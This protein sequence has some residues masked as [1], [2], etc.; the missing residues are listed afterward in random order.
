MRKTIVCNLFGGACVGKS[1][2]MAQVFADLKILGIECEMAPEYAKEKVW[3]ESFR[4]MDD[5][6][7]IF[8]KQLH[9]LNRLLGK[10]DVIICDS[11]LPF[12][13]IYDKSANKSFADLVLDQFNRFNNI[14]YL[15][16]RSTSYIPVG[17]LQN[18]EEAKEIDSRILTLLNEKGIKY[19]SIS[20]DEA[21]FIV[22]QRV[23]S[24][25]K[26]ARMEGGKIGSCI[27]ELN[28]PGS[29]EEIFERA[30]NLE[31]YIREVSSMKKD[32]YEELSKTLKAALNESPIIPDQEEDIMEAWNNIRCEG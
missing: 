24:E 5:Q 4:V 29:P 10:V 14:N 21:K 2:L 15:I 25:V 8:A 16:E 13:L 28:L 3:D 23:L 27:K 7:Y 32:E 9:K 30:C 1:V 11:P 18:E 12:S 19:E 6:I 17:R 22:I 31:K 26:K 20:K